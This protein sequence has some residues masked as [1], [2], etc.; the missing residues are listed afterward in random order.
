MV[1]TKQDIKLLFVNIC[2][3]P[4][5]VSKFLP[6]GLASV[7]TYFKTKGYDFTLLDTDIN[8]YDDVYVENY[9]KQT[10]LILF[11]VV[12]LLHITNGLNGL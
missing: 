6:V 3:R 1:K 9:K 10:S 4:G 12:L 7:M 2:L 11:F 8:E 5:G